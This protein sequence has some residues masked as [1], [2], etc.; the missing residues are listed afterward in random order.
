MP[1]SLKKNPDSL[2]TG[3]TK[4][5]TAEFQGSYPTFK[6]KSADKVSPSQKA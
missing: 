5:I 6:Q 2:G 3:Q 1:E 4:E